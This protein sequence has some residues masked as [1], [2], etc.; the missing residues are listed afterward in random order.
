MDRDDLVLIAVILCAVL[1]AALDLAT[2][3]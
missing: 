3:F 1:L 2:G